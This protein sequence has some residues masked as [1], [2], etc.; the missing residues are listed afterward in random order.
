VRITTNE[1]LDYYDDGGMFKN[2]NQDMKPEIHLDVRNTSH[3]DEAQEE[4]PLKGY[5]TEA[6]LLK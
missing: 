2:N 5:I 6:Q 4:E 3:D 1:D